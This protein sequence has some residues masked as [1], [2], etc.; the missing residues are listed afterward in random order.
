MHLPPLDVAVPYPIHTMS[1]GLQGGSSIH[2]ISANPEPSPH[3]SLDS[4]NSYA[5]HPDFASIQKIIRSVY[6]SPGLTVRRAERIQG[7][8]HQVFVAR[9][10]EKETTES[11]L[12]LKCPPTGNTRLLRHERNSLETERKALETLYTYTRLPVFARVQKYDSRGGPNGSAFLMTTYLPGSRLSELSPYLSAA[13]KQTIEYSLG[14]YVRQLSQISASQQNFGTTNRVYAKKGYKT[15]RDAFTA[16]LEALLKDGED[17]SVNL[18]YVEIRGWVRHHSHHLEEVT[19]PRLVALNLCEPQNVLVDIM[20]D[21]MR[22]ITGLLGFSNV[23]WGDPLMNG[24]IDLENGSDAFF[25]GYGG[26]PSYTRGVIVRCLMYVYWS[27][28]LVSTTCS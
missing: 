1:H 28:A 13:E 25:D 24:G 7:R 12:V 21:G 18:P 27:H 6:R 8:L 17:M 26:R 11:C 4:S 16:L 14:M 20:A 10:D 5:P 22:K 2:Q 3:P 9:L 23:L 19:H 15:W